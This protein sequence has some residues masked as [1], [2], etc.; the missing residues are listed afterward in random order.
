MGR[1]RQGGGGF[2]CQI[3][4]RVR[5]LPTSQVACVLA[6][7]LSSLSPHPTQPS[8]K[9]S[10]ESPIYRSRCPAAGPITY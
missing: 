8:S 2:D 1:L 7:P 6:N 3:L 4:V 5:G 9:L 10:A